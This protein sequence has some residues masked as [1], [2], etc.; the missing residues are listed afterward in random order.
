M[1]V[2]QITDTHLFSEKK[3]ELQGFC[4]YE[5][6]TKIIEYIINFEE[7]RP[8]YILLTGDISQDESIDSYEFA[9]HEFEKLGVPVYWIHGN[10]DSEM[11]VEEVFKKSDNLIRLNKLSTKFWDFLSIN[12][13]R[14]GIDEGYIENCEIDIF[15][16]KIEESKRD[17]KNIAVVMHHHPQPVNTPLVDECGLKN[18]EVFLDILKDN[19]SVKLVICGH[20]HGDY[21]IPFE[22]KMIETCPATCFQWKKGTENI[23]TENMRG[24]KV[25]NFESSSYDSTTIWI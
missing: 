12:T 17:G 25:F 2:I 4:T 15:L 7:E 9:L 19:G 10:H 3:A 1:K 13:C 22:L 18:N 8:D 16:K 23:E 14:H 20:V 11:A 21:Q 6:L 24:F 5:A